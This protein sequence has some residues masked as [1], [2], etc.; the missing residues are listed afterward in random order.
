M[1]GSTLLDLAL[2]LVLALQLVAGYREGLLVGALSTAGLLAGAVLGVV[3]APRLLAGLGT[4]TTRSL[5]VVVAVVLLALLGRLLLGLTGT[6]LRRRVRWRPVRV[7]DALLGA[8]AGAVA[9]ALVIWVAAGALRSTTL[10]SVSGAVS[11][12]RVIST[13]EAVV[14]PSASGLLAS[15]WSSAES[16]G[17]PR[18]FTALRDETVRPVDPPA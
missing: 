1:S 8:T 2:L 4:G 6:L 11:G 12:S 5:A 16:T 17:F 3:L 18:V 7:L 15:L 9:T 10:V 14:P 13:V